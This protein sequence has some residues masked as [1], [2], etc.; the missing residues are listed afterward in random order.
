MAKPRKHLE[1]LEP[2]PSASATV[3]TQ[4]GA[5]DDEQDGEP[6]SGPYT[7]RHGR[8]DPA[9]EIWSMVVERKLRARNSNTVTY[10]QVF[11]YDRQSWRSWLMHPPVD[12]VREDCGPGDYRFSVRYRGKR[13][14]MET[15]PD[16]AGPSTFTVPDLDGGNS[17]NNGN[18]NGNAS[19]P[20]PS[21]GG[22]D[23][24]NIIDRLLTQREANSYRD[25]QQ[26]PQHNPQQSVAA[27]ANLLA[28][29]KVTAGTANRIESL[30]GQLRD[31]LNAQDKENVR[32]LSEFRDSL[33]DL[34][35]TVEGLASQIEKLATKDPL[36]EIQRIKAGA[37]ALGMESA[38]VSGMVKEGLSTLRDLVAVN[39]GQ[40][41]GQPQLSPAAA[42]AAGT[43]KQPATTP[44]ATATAPP[45]HTSDDGVWKRLGDLVF[46]TGEHLIASHP[47]TTDQIC[48]EAVSRLW[49]SEADCQWFC[50]HTSNDVRAIFVYVYGEVHE[51]L[52]NW[53]AILPHVDAVLHAFPVVLANTVADR[54]LTMPDWL[55]TALVKKGH[56]KPPVP[57]GAPG[58][59]SNSEQAPGGE[60][61][62]GEKSADESNVIDTTANTKEAGD[63][64]TDGGQ[65]PDADAGTPAGVTTA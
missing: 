18:G 39:A 9:A 27:D 10:T 49:E 40:Q 37:S 41:P 60:Q 64:G 54:K 28:E 4:P 20:A 31:T 61:P 45:W 19:R 7:D 29:V 52:N 33:R 8:P 17:Y 46:W 53:Q 63:V 1:G 65:Q 58:P 23:P 11:S 36:T 26:Y 34:K 25:Q 15:Y 56:L 47:L 5:N 62:R 38:G 42:S 12:M 24:N 51:L 48:L 55:R 13:P 44:A 30:L 14:D 6:L 57:K 50:E 43:Q 16:M 21:P 22:L 59:K 35:S 32:H 3:I 2:T